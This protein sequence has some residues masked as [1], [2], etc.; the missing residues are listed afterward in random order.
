MNSLTPNNLKAMVQLT[1]HFTLEEL[2]QSRT[3]TAYKLSNEPTPQIAEALRLLAVH[4]LEPARNALGFP[5]VVSSGYRCPELNRIVGG[6]PSSQHMKG[7]AVD[8]KCQDNAALFAYIYRY[9][10]FDQL[11]WELGNDLQPAWVHV[12]YSGRN[13]RQVLRA[14]RVGNK[15]V[16]RPFGV[17]K[18]APNPL[19]MA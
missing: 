11:I 9:L 17:S 16:L 2:S 14:Y 7:E 19:R 3:A 13:R 4:I 1:P 6:S 18:F 5:L 8:L 12:S 15:M 10:P